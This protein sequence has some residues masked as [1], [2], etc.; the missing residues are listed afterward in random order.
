MDLYTS[1]GIMVPEKQNRREALCRDP[2]I[3]RGANA[4]GAPTAAADLPEGVQRRLASLADTKARIQEYL[5]RYGEAPVQFSAKQAKKVLNRCLANPNY[6]KIVSGIDGRLSEIVRSDEF[7]AQLAGIS[8]EQLRSANP[9]GLQR[10]HSWKAAY[11]GND[12]D[13]RRL[14]VAKLL[15]EYRQVKLELEANHRV[16]M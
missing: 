14:N 16:E 9:E 15:E 2:K 4:G 1:C 10:E 3:H 12:Y 7:R 13:P 5:E 11:G 6:T 8:L